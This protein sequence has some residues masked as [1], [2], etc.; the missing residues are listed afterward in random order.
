MSKFIESQDGDKLPIPQF[1]LDEM[2]INPS[3]IMIAKRGGGKSWI[4]RAILY[5]NSDI[6]V[7]LIIAPTDRDNIFYGT[8]YP[9]S[10][11]YY[12]YDSSIIRKLL[13]RQRLMIKKAAEKK[14]EGKYVDPRAIII[15]D[16]CLA[17]KGKWVSDPLIK[18]LL[19]NG[20]HRR[21]TYL[22]TM[23]FPL[24]ITPELRVNFDYIFLL[25]E[26][27]TSNLKRLFEH[28]AGMFPDFQSF[29]QIFTQLTSDFGAM[30]IKNR[31][32]RGGLID[33]VAFYKAPDLE[34]QTVKFGCKQFR[35]YHDKNF[36]K[37]WEDKEFQQ[38]LEEYIMEKRKTKSKIDVKKI[39][40]EKP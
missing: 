28:Y 25:A 34:G 14:L 15:M 23:Q 29:K 10:F 33:K 30:V 27:T 16:D 24:G 2:V 6:P 39:Y 26:D 1:S 13:L 17:S 5:K 40:T 11:I 35:K 12:E 8:F 18:D 31:G 19:F 20:R 38:D 22:L 37:S 4:S 36:D 21:I 3:I 7:G 9:T 32:I